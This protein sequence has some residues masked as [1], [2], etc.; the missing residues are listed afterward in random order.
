MRCFC[1]MSIYRTNYKKIWS[2][3]AGRTKQ[4]ENEKSWI[5]D[6]RHQ[7]KIEEIKTI[8]H[9]KPQAEVWNKP[10]SPRKEIITAQQELSCIGIRSWR[11]WVKTKN[12]EFIMCMILQQSRKSWVSSWGRRWHWGYRPFGQI[13]RKEKSNNS[14]QDSK[15]RRDDSSCHQHTSWNLCRLLCFSADNHQ[16]LL[17]WKESS[18]NEPQ[19]VQWRY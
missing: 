2:W 17:N 10:I 11:Y 5:A 6:E 4:E 3:A 19:I 18:H 16:E 12:R 7:N 8:L 14:A 15:Y 1:A 13:W 9:Q